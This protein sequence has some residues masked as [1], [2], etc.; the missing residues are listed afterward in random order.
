MEKEYFLCSKIVADSFPECEKSNPMPT[1]YYI[2]EPVFIVS[3]DFDKIEKMYNSLSTDKQ[4]DFWC[5][6][7]V[8]G[9]M[10]VSKMTLK[11]IRE[12][13]LL[14]EIERKTGLTTAKNEAMCVFNLCEK[15]GLEPMYFAKKITKKKTKA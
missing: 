5:W 8:P 2:Y 4:V 14:L 11:G 10:D 1:G 13:G 12:N 9:T 6:Q 3:I 15:F 7:L